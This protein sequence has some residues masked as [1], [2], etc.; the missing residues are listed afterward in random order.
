MLFKENSKKKIVSSQTTA[1]R[2]YILYKMPGVDGL[3]NSV[4]NSVTFQKYFLSILPNTAPEVDGAFSPLADGRE[5]TVEGNQSVGTDQQGSKYDIV[6]LI[7]A[8]LTRAVFLAGM[9]QK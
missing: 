9:H 1:P 4:T 7:P 2:F 5:M 6:C 3:V 8:A